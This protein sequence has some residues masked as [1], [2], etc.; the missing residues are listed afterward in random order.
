MGTEWDGTLKTH[1]NNAWN[2]FT[3]GAGMIMWGG[4]RCWAVIPESNMEY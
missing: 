1:S 2:I 3:N 4:K